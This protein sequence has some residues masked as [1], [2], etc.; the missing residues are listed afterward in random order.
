MAFAVIVAALAALS[1][2]CAVI[3]FQAIAAQR[4]SNTSAK[5]QAIEQLAEQLSGVLTP[6][7]VAEHL[8][9]SRLEADELLRGMVDDQRFTMAVDDRAGVIKFWYPEL[10]RQA[11]A[12]ASGGSGSA[13]G[14]ASG[15]GSDSAASA[16]AS[17]DA[18]Q[19]S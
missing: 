8:E 7:T 16:A 2:A 1:S 9:I 11:E 19:M 6:G 3:L 12:S 14:S 15:S 17:A 4:H 5:R 10:L 13:S 18:R